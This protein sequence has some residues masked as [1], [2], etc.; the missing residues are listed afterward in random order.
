MAFHHCD[1]LLHR[2]GGGLFV[3][4]NDIDALKRRLAK[5][6]G[7]S[8]IIKFENEPDCIAFYGDP[9]HKGTQIEAL[10][11]YIDVSD[12]SGAV[13]V[14][15]KLPKEVRGDLTP[16]EFENEQFCERDLE[17]YLQVHL[18]K[19]EAGLKL[20]GRQY[21]TKVGPI[22]LFAK[23]K[24]GD[25][26]ILELKKGRAADKVF[27]QICRYM[28]CIKTEQSQRG[29]A[30]RGYIVGREIDEKLRYA[31]KVLADGVIRM[32]TFELNGRLGEADWV[33]VSTE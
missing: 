30:V 12:V 5:H 32:Q 8:E 4:G 18:D 24:N 2:G 26:V 33:R 13:S 17:E 1:L 15:K 19:V 22:D 27:G 23:A 14:F 7:V 6:R 16:E 10:D 9:A 20:I 29:P 3:H 28:G 25:L 31:A 11:Y 21:S